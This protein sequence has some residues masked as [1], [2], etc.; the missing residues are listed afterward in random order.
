MHKTWGYHLSSN[1]VTFGQV[2]RSLSALVDAK[3]SCEILENIMTNYP[4]FIK[5]D[6][7]K[8]ISCYGRFRYNGFGVIFFYL[9]ALPVLFHKLYKRLAA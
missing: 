2:G 3:K 7:K 1:A 6:D 9:K 8:C 5:C 4:K